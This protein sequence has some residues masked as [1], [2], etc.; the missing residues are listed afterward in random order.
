[1]TILIRLID[2]VTQIRLAVQIICFCSESGEGLWNNHLSNRWFNY[3]LLS[4][5]FSSQ[6][7]IM[8]IWFEALIEWKDSWRSKIKPWKTGTLKIYERLRKR[9]GTHKFVAWQNAYVHGACCIFQGALRIILHV[10][11]TWCCHSSGRPQ[12]NFPFRLVWT[13]S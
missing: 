4:C 12:E 1:M 9:E 2:L 10:I 11:Y 7:G 8:R 13:E 5:S 3:F 6:R